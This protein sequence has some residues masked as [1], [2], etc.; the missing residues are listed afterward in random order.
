MQFYFVRVLIKYSSPI[1]KWLEFSNELWGKGL[2]HF[3][4]QFV[5]HQL[6][7]SGASFR[8]MKTHRAFNLGLKGILVRDEWD[9]MWDRAVKAHARSFNNFIIVGQTGIGVHHF[10]QF[11][12]CH[13]L[14]LRTREDSLSL[15]PSCKAFGVGSHN[16]FSKRSWPCMVVRWQRGSPAC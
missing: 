11:P 10:L 15:L 5:E 6:D 9:I 4:G 13:P 1:E 7:N 2:E 16:V 14:T 12:S 3:L 8:I